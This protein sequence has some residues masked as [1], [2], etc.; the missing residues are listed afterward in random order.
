[1][2]YLIGKYLL[3]L[4]LKNFVFIARVWYFKESAQSKNITASH[5]HSLIREIQ[6]RCSTRYKYTWYWYLYR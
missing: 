3:S 5:Q 1:M 4:F 2:L 6:S